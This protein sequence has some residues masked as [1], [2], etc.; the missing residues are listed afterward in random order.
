M[1]QLLFLLARSTRS[2]LDGQL[3]SY[4]VL[5]ISFCFL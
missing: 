3:I 1:L 4:G 2:S 5:A